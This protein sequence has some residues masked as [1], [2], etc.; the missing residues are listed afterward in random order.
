MNAK[1]KSLFNRLN[2]TEYSTEKNII[3]NHCTDWRG[4]YK[5]TSDVIFFQKI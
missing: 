5:G 2:K 1:F 4:K 3:E